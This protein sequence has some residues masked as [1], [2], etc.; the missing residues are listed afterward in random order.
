MGHS[1]LTR[2]RTRVKPVPG[3]TGMGTASCGYWV[4]TGCTGQ[5]VG[6]AGQGSRVGTGSTWILQ[7]LT[8]KPAASSLPHGAPAIVASPPSSVVSSPSSPVVSPSLSVVSPSLTVV[9]SL[10][11][12]AAAIA[13]VDVLV[14]VSLGVAAVVL[15]WFNVPAASPS[16]LPQADAAPSCTLLTAAAAAATAARA[17]ARQFQRQRR[18]DIDSTCD[19]N[20]NYK[21]VST[22]LST[23]RMRHDFGHHH[24]R[25]QQDDINGNDDNDLDSDANNEQLA[26]PTTTIY[27]RKKPA[28]PVIRVQVLNGYPTSYP[29]P[30]P[31]NP[32]PGT[33]AGEGWRALVCPLS[34][35]T[36]RG[37][38]G[39]PCAAVPRE[40]DGGMW[41]KGRGP[42]GGNVPS[43]ALL[44][45][46]GGSMWRA[47]EGEEGGRLTLV[48]PCLC[49]NG[50]AGDVGERS[51]G[52]S[53]CVLYANGA[54]GGDGREEGGGEGGGGRRE[55]EEEGGGRREEGGGRREEGG[56]RREEGGG[57][58]EE[59]GGKDLCSLHQPDSALYTNR[60]MQEGRPTPHIARREGRT[61]IRGTQCPSASQALPSPPSVPPRLRGRGAHEGMPLPLFSLSAAPHCGKWAHEGT[62]P[63]PLPFPLG[64]AIRKGGTRPPAPL[65]PIRAEGRTRPPP[66]FPLAAP[67]HSRRM[68]ACE[69][70]T[71]R[72]GTLKG[73]RLLG[74]SLPR[75]RG[76]G[77]REAC[78]PLAP[79]PFARKGGTRGHASPRRP[80]PLPLLSSRH[81]ACEARHPPALPFPPWPRR[82]I[83]VGNTRACH[84]RF[85]PSPFTRRPQPFPLGCTAPYAWEVGMQ[86]ATPGATLP[87][88]A[89]KGVARGYAAQ[90]LPSPLAALPGTREK[91]ARE[92]IRAEGGAR[93]HAAPFAREGAHKGKLSPPPYV[94]R[95]GV[96]AVSAC[97]RSPRPH[98]DFRAP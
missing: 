7:L 73:T 27:T 64:R 87:P 41:E 78:H 44:E 68:G 84:P 93:G 96:D 8:T 82:P 91:G 20:D 51:V 42:E 74:P 19:N 46:G 30:Y 67:P 83:R 11:A 25:F 80:R 72:K 17:Q 2:T 92:G 71:R 28:K 6:T 24:H 5:R 81:Q 22:A 66:P 31:S 43:Y 56:G 49:T 33:R 26:T 52:P 95:S 69:G 32:Y 86:S 35:Q 38:A 75:S 10:S 89:R 57:R 47:G 13:V 34:A 50:A 94:S 79:S 70:K 36:G 55:E 76:K 90:H 4:L 40:W 61:R 15:L 16:L 37:A 21:T 48:H 85:H 12:A 1:T 77:A 18:Q 23:T 45:W 98:H 9:S 39:C 54:G 58:R 97:P 60:G 53:S 14:V 88:L 63:P 29:Y 62:W 3:L 65:F 59:G